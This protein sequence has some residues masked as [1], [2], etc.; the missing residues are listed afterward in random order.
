MTRE[1]A[2]ALCDA[3]YITVAEYLAFVAGQEQK[4]PT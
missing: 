4:P 3:G 2:C 1:M